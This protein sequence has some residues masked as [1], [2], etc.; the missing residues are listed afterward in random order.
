MTAK[1]AFAIAAVPVLA[2]TLAFPHSAQGQAPGVV[3]SEQICSFGGMGDLNDMVRE[4]WTPVLNAAVADGRLTGWGVLN[5]TWG[6]EWN[7]VMYYTGPDAGT[8]TQ[9]VGSL[10]GEI[11]ASMPGNPMDDFDAKCS[12][13]R[14]NAYVVVMTHESTAGAGGQND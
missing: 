5:H 11:F 13:H 9:T 8:L 10:L 7:W 14:D 4:Y 3:V 6:S 1:A 12:A 2:L